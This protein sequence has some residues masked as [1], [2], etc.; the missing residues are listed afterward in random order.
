MITAT[1]GGP[2]TLAQV[3]RR[4]GEVEHQYQIP[5]GISSLAVGDG[6]IWIASRRFA[7]LLRFDPSKEGV[8]RRVRV[9]SNRA[10][11]VAFGA[12]AAWV[13]SPQ[14]D[15]VTRVDASSYDP[16]RI[17]VGRGPAGLDVRGNDV[18]VAD[19]SDNTVTRI[20]ARSAQKV[21]E[22]IPVPVNPF[23]V[24]IAGHSVWVTCQPVNRVVRI[25]FKPVTDRGG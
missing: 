24:A 23:A 4:T 17:A 12:G 11:G 7:L 22:P 20:D 8:T 18:F 5:E 2:D 15:L 3:D 10:Y 13:S 25:D 6:A 19:S 14:D 9:G 21:G 16:T 1:K